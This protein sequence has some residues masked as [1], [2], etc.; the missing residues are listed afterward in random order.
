MLAEE[1][2]LLDSPNN[3]SLNLKDALKTRSSD[4]VS[5][6][7]N[8]I[9]DINIESKLLGNNA[10]LSKPIV[11]QGKQESSKFLNIPEAVPVELP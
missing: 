9:S 5:Q 4:T 1:N 6:K 8:K 7:R 3:V 10:E 2:K 11:K